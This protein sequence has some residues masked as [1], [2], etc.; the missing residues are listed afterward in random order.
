MIDLFFPLRIEDRLIGVLAMSKKRRGESYTYEEIELITYALSSVGPGIDRE[1]VREQLQA[2]Q[3]S[4]ALVNE[5]MLVMSSSIDISEA[6]DRFSEQL[7]EVVPI[8]WAAI[9]LADEDQ[10]HIL[11]ILWS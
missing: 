6:F 11:A 4:L 3:R 2:N 5:L 1:Y 10:L 7:G 8:D 9:S